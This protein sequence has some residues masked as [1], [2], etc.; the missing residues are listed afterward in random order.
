MVSKNGKRETHS[1]RQKLSTDRYLTE[2]ANRSSETININFSENVNWGK[3][4]EIEAE[5]QK[6]KY[7]K[8][9]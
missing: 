5:E 2:E 3:K 8:Y 4:Q 7:R 6:E 1:Q 9:S